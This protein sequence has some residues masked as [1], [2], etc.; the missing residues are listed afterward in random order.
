MS[1]AKIE[2]A[3]GSRAA[4]LG[5]G[6]R[7]GALET[8]QIAADDYSPERRYRIYARKGE[9][10]RELAATPNP[11]GIGAALVQLHEDGQQLD[12]NG[13]AANPKYRLYNEGMI[14]V[15]DTEKHEWIVLPW[16]RQG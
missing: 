4:S 12:E 15:L 8:I 3:R 16:G 10:L 11:S 1:R 5:G 7:R 14:G 6:A 9:D 2:G 13:R